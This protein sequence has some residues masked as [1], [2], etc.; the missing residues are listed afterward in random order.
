MMLLRMSVAGALLIAV[1]AAVR[2]LLQ[3]RLHRRV[4]LV[5]WAVAVLRLLVPV[6]VSSPLIPAPPQ[7]SQAASPVIVEAQQP[8]ASA[9]V[10][11]ERAAA[12]NT[13]T[14]LLCIWAGG[15]VVCALAFSVNHLRSCL[16]YRYSMP[17]P[18]GISV[19]DGLRVR[20]LDELDAPLTYGIMHP[21]VLLPC[22]F[23][24]DDSQRLRHVLLHE[25]AHIRHRDVLGKL[26]LLIALCL[27][28]F[29]PMVWLM[30]Y[31]A[32]QD[33]EMRCDAEV[34]EALGRSER[35]AY[36]RT[37]V[38]AEQSRLSGFLLTGFS[39]S[40]TAGRIKAISRGK[41]RRFVSIVVCVAMLPLICLSFLT[42]LSAAAE[43]LEPVEPPV[44][45]SQEELPEFSSDNAAFDLPAMKP[46]FVQD[47]YTPATV[48][49]ETVP[50]TSEELILTTVPSY[51]EPVIRLVSCPS[52]VTVGHA[53]IIQ[54]TATADC[55]FYSDNPAAVHLSER[56]LPYEVGDPWFVPPGETQPSRR[57]V[58]VL[59]E[60]SAIGVGTANIYC[61]CEGQSYWLGTVTVTPDGTQE[62]A[63]FW[64]IDESTEP[65]VPVVSSVD[66]FIGIFPDPFGG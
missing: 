52:S 24:W 64:Q 12:F 10:P 1:I 22:N 32:S 62:T 60:L 42:S 39:F 56:W 31:L 6:F 29:N 40:S 44:I 38:S 43:P 61:E 28:W 27:H 47:D 25:Q 19:P 5:L 3:H 17:I 9:V 11:P 54:I 2:A 63:E 30:F 58:T 48:P 7:A 53:Q 59:C 33:M 55:R 18:D 20:M 16:R 8:S 36:A 41:A 15:A 45:P 23:P 49:S 35:L 14:L 51:S 65:F 4:L 21:I 46:A 34:I 26:I 13:E 37:L 57:E 66:D 50:T